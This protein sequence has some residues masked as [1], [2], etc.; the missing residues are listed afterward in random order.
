MFGH[1]YLQGHIVPVVGEVERAKVDTR[2]L[3][4]AVHD[5]RVDVAVLEATA[6]IHRVEAVFVFQ[7]ILRFYEKRLATPA[8]G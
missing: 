6:D 8:P 2:C 3:R 1:P 7:E 5:M 4:D